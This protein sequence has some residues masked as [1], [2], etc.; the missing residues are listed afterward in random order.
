VNLIRFA[1]GQMAQLR[2]GPSE[3]VCA[4]FSMSARAAA[5]VSYAARSKTWMRR[6]MTSLLV[7]DTR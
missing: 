6:E 1:A 4:T 5:G 2:A 7:P 3:V